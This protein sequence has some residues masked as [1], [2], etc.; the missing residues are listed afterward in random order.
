MVCFWYYLTKPI[1]LLC[2]CFSFYYRVRAATYIAQTSPHVINAV[3]DA[4]GGMRVSLGS[5][6]VLSYTLQGLFHPARKVREVYWKIYNSLYIGAQVCRA[7]CG[8]ADA[9]WQDAL[10]AAYPAIPDDSKN[11]YRRAEM[12]YL[13]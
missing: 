5:H 9:G 6:R 2:Y 3:L 7:C 4:V 13:L 1:Y 10:V 8:V 12:E 11:G